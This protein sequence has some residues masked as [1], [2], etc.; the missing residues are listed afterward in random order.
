MVKIK[1]KKT[2]NLKNMCVKQ[3]SSFN[4]SSKQRWYLTCLNSMAKNIFKGGSD[5]VAK[6]EL[7]CHVEKHYLQQ[8]LQPTSQIEELLTDLVYLQQFATSST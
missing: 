7:L 2:E 8:R 3:L 4:E 5:S 1:I 6:L